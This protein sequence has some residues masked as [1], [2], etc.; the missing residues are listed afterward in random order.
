M[1]RWTRAPH[2]PALPPG[3]PPSHCS[4]D[5]P[6]QEPHAAPACALPTQSSQIITVE[7]DEVSGAKRVSGAERDEV[8]GAEREALAVE[9]SWPFQLMVRAGF[10]ARALTYG[11]I[12]GI[13]SALA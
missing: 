13:A 9:R 8:S 3:V 7:R 11:V 12:G 5:E 10:V 6:S 1:G 4:Q 2:A